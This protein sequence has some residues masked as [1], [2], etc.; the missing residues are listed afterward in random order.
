[1]I[2]FGVAGLGKTCLIMAD[3]TYGAFDNGVIKG[4]VLSPADPTPIVWKTDSNITTAFRHVAG[5]W[6]LFELVH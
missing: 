3:I 5:D 4:Y 1:M 2:I 6:Y